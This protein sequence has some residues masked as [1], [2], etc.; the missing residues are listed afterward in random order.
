RQRDRRQEHHH[1]PGRD[2]LGPPVRA[3]R[4]WYGA[5]RRTGDRRAD[6]SRQYRVG[7]RAARDDGTEPDKAGPPRPVRAYDHGQGGSLDRLSP[8]SGGRSPCVRG[9][10]RIV[11]TPLIRRGP[12][13]SA[14][15]H[16]L[17]MAREWDAATYDRIADP[18][19]RWGAA[20]VDRLQLAGDERVLD[21]GCGSGRVTEL[22]LGRLPRGQV[23]ALDASLA[24]VE[25]AQRRL[26]PF[27]NRVTFVV[28]DLLEPLPIDAAVD[29]VLSTATFHW[30][31]DH[32]SL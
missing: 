17:A 9:P 24:M 15:R 22:L 29:G 21:A 19:T 16:T 8:P 31:T 13:M 7:H 10:H 26:T 4:P 30:I 3:W 23:I 5:H 32:E 12:R 20:V 2:P 18:M 27:G 1:Q 28:A 14:A 25:E 6:R 11:R